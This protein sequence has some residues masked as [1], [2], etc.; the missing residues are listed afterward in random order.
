MWRFMFLTLT[1]LVYTFV[2]SSNTA[3]TT[4]HNEFLRVVRS[5]EGALQQMENLAAGESYLIESL[6]TRQR[7]GTRRGRGV[8]FAL[9]CA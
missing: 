8:G 1:L 3:G 7:A 6:V 9:E 4:L 5:A 2:Y